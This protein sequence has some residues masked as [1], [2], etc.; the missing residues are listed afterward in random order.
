MSGAAREKRPYVAGVRELM[1]PLD[2]RWIFLRR[3]DGPG[4]PR[5]A[6][7][8]SAPPKLFYSALALLALGLDA[9]VATMLLSGAAAGPIS[10]VFGLVFIPLS[11]ILLWQV[12]FMHAGEA[13]LSRRGGAL[14]Y[15]RAMLG[16]VFRARRAEA[17]FELSIEERPGR[18]R[19]LVLVARGAG[20]SGFEIG[21]V[22]KEEFLL[23]MPEEILRYCMEVFQDSEAS[24]GK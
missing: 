13:S 16:R 21:D 19:N 4:G 14:V 22:R 9:L 15:E 20:G 12:A 18:K 7:A 8:Y 1:N 11:F 5:L 6:L 10:Y 3:A 24:P 2:R 17:P 23:R